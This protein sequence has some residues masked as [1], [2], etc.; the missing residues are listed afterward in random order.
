MLPVESRGLCFVIAPIGKPGSP[1]RL[2]SDLV[3][4]KLIRP[5]MEECEYQPKRADHFTE[6][7]MITRDIIESVYKAP[8]VIAN[9]T[10]SNPNVYYE[11]ALRH[12]LEKPVILIA[13]EGQ[14]LPFDISGNRAI[15]FNLEDDQNLK[16][17]QQAIIKQVELIERSPDDYYNP[18]SVSLDII[19][20]LDDAHFTFRDVRKALETVPDLEKELI[21]RQYSKVYFVLRSKGIFTKRELREFMSDEY[22]LNNLRKAY[23]E[24]L[25]RSEDHPIDPMAIAYWGADLY[26]SSQ[27]EEAEDAIELLRHNLRMSPEYTQQHGDLVIFSAQFGANNKYD[28]KTLIVKREVKNNKLH[29]FVS[30]DT[31]GEA[32]KGR[33]KEL[34]VIYSYKGV[35]YPEKIVM[36]D[37]YL[38]LP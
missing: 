31:L 23:I 6:P 18:I 35:L 17:C 28:D 4:E 21:V 29:F 34:K 8:I 14:D 30:I 38:D 9:L 20:A 37:E 36:E 10:G 25:L 5:A 11:L 13:P 15:F 3:F 24:E 26:I 22:I 33:R 19:T 2:H 27:S 32:F 1:E 16:R 12:T 7:G